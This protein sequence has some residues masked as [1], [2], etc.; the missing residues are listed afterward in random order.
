MRSRAKR[1]GDSDGRTPAGRGLTPHRNS[2]RHQVTPDADATMET[3]AAASPALA[4]T[5][6]PVLARKLP[7]AQDGPTTNNAARH[8]A[9]V[10]MLPNLAPAE[11]RPDARET[12][13]NNA[14]NREGDEGATD[15]TTVACA[16]GTP[17]PTQVMVNPAPA[18]TPTDAHDAQM[19]NNAAGH[20][21]LAQTLPA[22]VLAMMLS[23]F[24]EPGED[25]TNACTREDDDGEHR[26]S[27]TTHTTP[28]P[29]T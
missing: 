12:G 18:T 1:N 2:A 7:D 5:P 11:A 17:V 16:A 8:P 24:Y 9:L 3:T 14:S 25:Q 23:D 6:N 22:P 19:A 29:T 21:V 15:A 10:Q 13:T 27:D 20:P 26:R 4:Q 28:P